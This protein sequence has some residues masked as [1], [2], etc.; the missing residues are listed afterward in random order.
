[1]SEFAAMIDSLLPIH[2]GRLKI[3]F[4]AVE[5][6]RLLLT[7]G[8]ASVKLDD[9]VF[10]SFPRKLRIHALL[11]ISWIPAL[12]ARSP[13]K[14]GEHRKGNRRDRKSVPPTTA[15]VPAGM[16][17]RLKTRGPGEPRK[18]KA[19]N[20]ACN[21]GSFGIKGD[22]VECREQRLRLSHLVRS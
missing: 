3:E 18:P 13:A 8:D 15:H 6:W 14:N 5:L 4:S 16:T 7:G 10:S 22:C 11:R 19:G 12:R 9:Q 1:M 2:A 21:G 17:V 20:L